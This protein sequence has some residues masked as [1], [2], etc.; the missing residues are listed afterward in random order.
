MKLYYSQNFR[1]GSYESSYGRA[2]GCSKALQS[3]SCYDRWLAQNIFPQMAVQKKQVSRDLLCRA[4]S[5]CMDQ[6]FQV[7]KIYP[8]V[9]NQ[10]INRMNQLSGW[11]LLIYNILY[12]ERYTFSKYHF[13]YLFHTV[14]CLKAQNIEKDGSNHEESYFSNKRLGHFGGCAPVEQDMM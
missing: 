10:K 4:I 7:V 5:E 1:I 13:I 6:N 14:E 9:L 11:F 3:E 12:Y 8:A 2:P